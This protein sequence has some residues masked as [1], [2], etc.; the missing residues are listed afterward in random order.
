MA[1]RAISAQSHFNP[2]IFFALPPRIA[3]FSASEIG[4]RVTCA[5]SAPM[6]GSS[7]PNNNC[8]TPE[9][10]ILLVFEIRIGCDEN[11]VAFLLRRIK[12]LAVLELGPAALICGG[13]FMLRQ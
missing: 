6:N 7:L 2:S 1:Q 8:D 12:Q 10:K 11:R 5:V 13:D 3:A 4:S 9:L